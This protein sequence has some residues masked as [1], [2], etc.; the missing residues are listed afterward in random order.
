MVTDTISGTFFV[1]VITLSPPSRSYR[2]FGFFFSPP[3]PAIAGVF[4]TSSSC[5]NEHRKEVL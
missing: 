3:L 2:F 4:S 5:Y 1:C